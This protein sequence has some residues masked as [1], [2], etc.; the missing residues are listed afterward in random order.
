[1][2]WHKKPFN[3]VLTRFNVATLFKAKKG[4]KVPKEKDYKDLLIYC[5]GLMKKVLSGFV[6]VRKAKGL[7]PYKLIPLIS[8]D[9]ET[10]AECLI[11]LN[12]S[13]ASGKVATLIKRVG[14]LQQDID[15]NKLKSVLDLKERADKLVTLM[16]HVK[17]NENRLEYLSKGLETFSS[18]TKIKLDKTMHSMH[19]QEAPIIFIPKS[20]P[21]SELKLK[22]VHKIGLSYMMSYFYIKKSQF[23][24]CVMNKLNRKY[25]I[26]EQVN[27]LLRLLNKKLTSG[28]APIHEI[29]F[30]TK[31]FYVVWVVPENAAR[32]VTEFIRTLQDFQ[33]FVE[34]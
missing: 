15:N 8:R 11:I 3:P 6:E 7:V 10:I 24:V 22:L 30:K 34:E 32:D 26:E 14:K 21:S 2:K 12:D 23:M 31:R 17:I 29:H 19:I 28:L 16:E 27:I 20:F 9:L 33:I 4:G 1:M 5:E 18:L 13:H 25:K